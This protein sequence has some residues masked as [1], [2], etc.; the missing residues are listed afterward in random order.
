MPLPNHPIVPNDPLGLDHINE[1]FQYLEEKAE[2]LEIP[3]PTD[4]DAYYKKDEATQDIRSAI[5]GH[6]TSPDA[7]GSMR[8]S[9]AA[10]EGRL[11]SIHKVISGDGISKNL[12]QAT[13]ATL[14][15]VTVSGIWNQAQGRLEF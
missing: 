5:S 14:D 1:N 9:M 12:F 8:A 3:P 2:N 6:D 13:F 10:I 4:L 15:G 7:H 11:A